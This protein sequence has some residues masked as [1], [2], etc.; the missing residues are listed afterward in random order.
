MINN[1]F[2]SPE[3]TV[4]KENLYEVIA[5]RIEQ[6]ILDNRLQPGDKLPSEPELAERFGV[7]RNVLREAMKALKERDLIVQRNGDGTYVAKPDSHNV[8]A[9][10]NRI[11]TLNNIEY[12]DIYDM[13]LI[14][15]V[16][17][18]AKA[19]KTVDEDRIGTLNSLIAKMIE[20][21]NDYSARA[22]YD[23]Q[24]HRQIIEYAGN[25]LLACIYDSVTDLLE[26]ILEHGLR[27]EKSGHLNGIMWHK[28]I[29]EALVM[30]DAK[31]AESDMRQHLETSRALCAERGVPVYEAAKTE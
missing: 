8:T 1:I 29:V 17:A 14:L 15:E 18:C 4:K 24:F 3:I 27:T 9:V 12:S 13:R 20:S 6:M 16:P 19:A 10:L 28:R 7:S 22:V 23:L 30:G 11:I 31:Q 21:E 26:P 2:A 5:G 25:P